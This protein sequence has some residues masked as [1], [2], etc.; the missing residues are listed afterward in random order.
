VPGVDRENFAERL[1]QAT[2]HIGGGINPDEHQIHRLIEAELV[3][4]LQFVN[5]LAYRDRATYPEGHE[6]AGDELSGAEAYGLYGQVALEHVTKRGGRLTLYNEADLTLIGDADRRWD[7]IAIM[8][9]PA[10]DAFLDM[11]VDPDYVT[12]LVHRQ[13]G[14]DRTE[15]IVSRPLLPAP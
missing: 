12:A 8:E 4:P 7:Q 6:R 5:L 1:S 9:Y 3:G 10:L 14:L 15:V 13:A 11:I 2:G